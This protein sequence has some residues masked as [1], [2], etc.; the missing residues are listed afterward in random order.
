MKFKGIAVPPPSKGIRITEPDQ[1]VPDQSLSLREIIQ[2]FTRNEALPVGMK[3]QYG[4]DS[5]IDPESESEFNVDVEKSAHWDLTEKHEFIDRVKEVGKEFEA[6]EKERAQ[7]AAEKE[8][9]E[10]EK[11]I[12]RRVKAEARKLAAS[13]DKKTG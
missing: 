1:V 13:Q 11:A 10:R 5:G 9:A 6:A 3:G 7:R 12:A 8:A 2:R 4:S